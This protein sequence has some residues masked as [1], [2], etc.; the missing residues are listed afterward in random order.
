MAGSRLAVS[1]WLQIVANAGHA[2]VAVGHSTSRSDARYPTPLR[3]VNQAL[4]W[5]HEHANSLGLDAGRVVL[6]GSS[7]WAQISAQLALPGSSQGYARRVGIVPDPL[8]T[9]LRGLPLQALLQPWAHTGAGVRPA[10]QPQPGQPP[11]LQIHCP[12]T[13]RY[14]A[15]VLR[16]LEQQLD[17]HAIC[18]ADSMAWAI[19][20]RDRKKTVPVARHG[21]P[22]HSRTAYPPWMTRAPDRRDA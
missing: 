3:Q 13:H 11:L 15:H 9:R 1:H 4:G 6:G 16:N 10:E 17:S 14:L 8:L 19:R 12:S 20:L 2:C 5:L 7:A 22:Q 21:Q 18:T